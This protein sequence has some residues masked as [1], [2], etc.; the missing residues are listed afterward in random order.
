MIEAHLRA[1]HSKL[2]QGILR[3]WDRELPHFW[4]VVPKEILPML[5]A[6]LSDEESAEK[7]A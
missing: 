7:S 1:T 5:E 6:P 4:Q 3:D 2:A